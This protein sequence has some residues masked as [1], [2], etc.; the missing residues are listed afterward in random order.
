MEAKLTKKAILKKTAQISVLTLT[1]RMLG[2]VREILQGQFLGVGIESDAFITAFKIPNLLRKI[3]EDGGL[4]SALVP[5][6]VK[7]MHESGKERASRLI[8]ATLF[9]FESIMLLLCVG[10]IAFPTKIA[11]LIAPGF[12]PDQIAA[13]IPLMQIMFPLIMFFSSCT[14]VASALYAINHF[15]VPSLGPVFFNITYVSGLM[16]CIKYKWTVST[17]AWFVLAAGS[18]KLISRTITY[19]YYNFSFGLPDKECFDDLA[20]VFKRF[21]PCLTSFGAIELSLFLDSIIS[22]YLPKGSVTLLY[23]AQR[24][25]MMPHSIISVALSA[26]LLS[27][28]SKTAIENPKRLPFLMLESNKIVTWIS[29]PVMCFMMFVSYPLFANLMLK[30]RAT[31]AELAI[32]SSLLSIFLIGFPLQAVNK[33]MLNIFYANNDTTTPTYIIIVTTILVTALNYVGIWFIGIYAMALGA[34]LSAVLKTLLFGLALHYK[35][36]ITC[37]VDKFGSFLMRSLGQ[38]ACG[39]CIFAIFYVTLIRLIFYM[40]L[41]PIFIDGRGYWV[42]MLGLLGIVLFF[43]WKTQ[44]RFGIRLY[45]ASH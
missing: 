28:F 11:H 44:K 13:T 40:S 8:T 29:L 32:A 43:M 34:L 2:I 3:F 19:F 42:W 45:L 37:A 33:I 14:M 18:T 25:F 39:V 15:F 6:L 5:H 9:I 17:L 20:I 7:I 27:H 38:L 26:V 24:F 30:G 10:V 1:S 41:Q 21:L 22:S 12:S 36:G 16:L 4:S 23:Y 35:H 31:G